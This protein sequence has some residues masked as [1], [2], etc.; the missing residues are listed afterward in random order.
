V[1]LAETTAGVA[2]LKQGFEIV[3]GTLEVIS[4]TDSFAQTLKVLWISFNFIAAKLNFTLNGYIRI[5]T[6]K[7]DSVTVYSPEIYCNIFTNI[8]V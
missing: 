4:P 6:I 3:N 5:W 2:K 1:S 8:I 7:S